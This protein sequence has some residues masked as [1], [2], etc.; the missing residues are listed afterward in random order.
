MGQPVSQAGE[1][2]VGNVCDTNHPMVSKLPKAV[3]KHPEAYGSAHAM[4][5]DLAERYTARSVRSSR[6]E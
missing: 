1:A 3:L 5:R 4:L 6:V 2:P